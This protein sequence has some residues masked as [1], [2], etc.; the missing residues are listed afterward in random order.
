MNSEAM[1]VEPS[2]NS[3]WVV[4]SATHHIARDKGLFLEMKQKDVGQ[5]PALDFL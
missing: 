5:W 3:W 1:V 2:T 4:S